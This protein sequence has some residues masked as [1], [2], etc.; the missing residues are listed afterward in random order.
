VIQ[1]PQP[2]WLP[3]L[4]FAFP[5]ILL[6]ACSV[7][8][9]LFPRDDRPLCTIPAIGLVLALLPTHLLALA[10]G[11]LTAGL[12]VAWVII[13]ASGYAWITRHWGNFLSALSNEHAGWAG[14]LGIAAL[15]T[16]PIVL[17]TILL[18]F[19]DEA[20]FNGHHAI[21]AHLQN[22]SYPPR[23]LYEP[24][25]SLRYHYAFDLAS[26]I[27][28]GLLRVRVDHAIDLLTLTLWPCM[29][30][31]LWRVG[32]HVGARGA[33]LF[34]ALAVCYSGGW[35]AIAWAGSRCGFCA[36][37]GLRVNLP[38]IDNFFQHPWS[39]GVPIFCLV[40]LQRAALPWIG[41]R[42]LGLVALTCSLVLLSLSQAVLFITTLG[43]LGLTEAWRAVRF[44]DRGAERVLG[45]LVASL[46]G[47]RLSGGFFA[48]GPFPPAG[49]ILDTGFYIRNF[50]GI[51][52]VLAQVQWNVASF[53]A[54]LV[55]GF[56]GL[57]RATRDKIFLTILAALG[58]IIV[59]LLHYKYTWDIVKFGT[60]SFIA[61]AIGAGIALADLVVWARTFTRRAFFVGLLVAVSGQSFPYP[62]IML[63]AYDPGPRPPF[64]NQMIRPYFSQA[65]PVD[66]DD[67]RAVSFLRTH[68]S[69]LEI[70]YRVEEKSE[71]YAIW[72]GL[73]TQASVYAENGKADDAYGLGEEKL[74]ARRDLARVSENWLDRLSAAHVVWIVTDPD[75]SAIEDVL[76][77]PEGRRRALLAAQ[78]GNV[79][80]FRL[81]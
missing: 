10:L 41:N 3:L 16:L 64:S 44:R 7:N 55:L 68:M 72:G 81:N 35:P 73:P 71:P 40:V 79:R 13:G 76:A 32:D 33:G 53:G 60:I 31:L 69:P 11:S 12:T 6:A 70:V 14:R 30:L 77:S 48:S 5:G 28:T 22:G 80:V 36:I 19:Y 2:A 54:L 62:F 43:A 42:V 17:P 34:V 63:W 61:L 56:L 9:H 26:A 4:L 25:L 38:F 66:T 24:S 15:A 65:Y 46:L 21:I 39:I 75:D 45:S 50:T 29:F 37:N 8:E 49:G 57:R 18:N 59:N 74:T 1:N 23:Y 20:N 52:D 58:L 47:A 51:E 67:A 78:Y 27:V